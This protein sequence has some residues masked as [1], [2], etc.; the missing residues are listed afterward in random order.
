MPV[1]RFHFEP[2]AGADF[3]FE[4]EEGMVGGVLP[5]VGSGARGDPTFLDIAT[6]FGVDDI[7]VG[8]GCSQTGISS[9]PQAMQNDQDLRF[10]W[11]QTGQVCNQKPVVRDK[12]QF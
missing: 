2:E 1:G 12:P 9:A 7:G 11:L 5:E 8:A 4:P 6:V 10:V 3:G